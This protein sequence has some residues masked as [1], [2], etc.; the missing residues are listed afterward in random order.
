[1]IAAEATLGARFR[2]TAQTAIA[3]NKTTFRARFTGQPV[4]V[5]SFPQRPYF[6]L[7]N[8]LLM[9]QPQHR[10]QCTSSD[11][12]RLDRA[13]EAIL[14]TGAEHHRLQTKRVVVPRLGRAFAVGGHSGSSGGWRRRFRWGEFFPLRRSNARRAPVKARPH[15]VVARL[16]AG[17]WRGAPAEFPCN[18]DVRNDR[19]GARIILRLPGSGRRL[20]R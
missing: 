14:S 4:L 8:Q 18:S 13:R 16:E 2:K 1:M 12:T 20:R 15:G 19:L 3:R 5:V 17:P 11:S 9:L 6:I 7:L 10:R